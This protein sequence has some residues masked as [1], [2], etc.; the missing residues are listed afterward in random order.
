[1][2]HAVPFD[3][4]ATSWGGMFPGGDTS[5]YQGQ[6]MDTGVFPPTYGASTAPSPG[7]EFVNDLGDAQGT[8]GAGYRLPTKAGSKLPPNATSLTAKPRVGTGVRGLTVVPARA[9]SRPEGMPRERLRRAM[10]SSRVAGY[11]I[12]AG[13]RGTTR[14]GHPVNVR[15]YGVGMGT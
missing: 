1:L 5:R 15:P 8:L 4:A 10:A 2:A 11:G 6:A 3:V 9:V 14:N 7:V 13:G 12:R